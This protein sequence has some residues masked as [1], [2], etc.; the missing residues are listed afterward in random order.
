MIQLF[1]RNWIR[2]RVTRERHHEDR[3]DHRRPGDKETVGERAGEMELSK[4]V[5]EVVKGG[6]RRP[7]HIGDRLAIERGGKEP[8]KWPEEEGEHGQVEDVH[9]DPFGARAG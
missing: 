9:D 5:G 3:D 2:E 8:E 1:A 7:T 4:Y 6:R